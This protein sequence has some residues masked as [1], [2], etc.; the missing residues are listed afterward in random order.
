MAMADAWLSGMLGH[1]PYR[2]RLDATDRN[3]NFV[4]YFSR[5]TLPI[6]I[7]WRT[8]PLGVEQK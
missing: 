8:E 1:L 3:D 7:A 6:E 2:V 5:Q 4:R